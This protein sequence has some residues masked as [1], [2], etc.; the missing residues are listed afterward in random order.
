MSFNEG[1][2]LALGSRVLDCRRTLHPF[3]SGRAGWNLAV[4][5]LVK[6]CSAVVGQ[7]LQSVPEW[8]L[9]MWAPWSVQHVCGNLSSLDLSRRETLLFT[10]LIFAGLE[11]NLCF[12]IASVSAWGSKS[13]FLCSHYLCVYRSVSCSS[14]GFFPSWRTPLSD[15]FSGQRASSSTDLGSLL[16]H[17]CIICTYSFWCLIGWS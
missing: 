8:T 4:L 16:L 14:P 12:S 7:A 2:P 3:F 17:K 13:R 10:E 6:P 15:C 1:N 5:W 11:S 9:S